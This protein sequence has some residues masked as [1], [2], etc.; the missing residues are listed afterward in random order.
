MNRPDRPCCPPDQDAVASFATGRI[1]SRGD[2][3][4]PFP[5]PEGLWGQMAEEGLFRIGMDG[6]YG[7][8]GGGY[9][10]LAATG[11]TL[12]RQGRNMGVALS[13]LYQQ[14]VARFLIQGFGSSD[15]R[16]ACLPAMAEGRLTV[17]FAVSEPG[18]GAHPKHLAATASKDGPSYL[19]NGEKAYL[20]NGPLADAFIVVAVSSEGPPRR[21]FTAFLVPRDTPG[22]TVAPPLSVP[23]LHPAPHGGIGLSDCRVP[24]AAVLGREGTAYEDMVI[25]FGDVEDALWGA[26]ALGGMEAQIDMLRE[27]PANAP[28]LTHESLG[29]L[30]VQ[31]AALG[32]ICQA[33]V[34]RL[35]M[36]ETPSTALTLAFHDLS[37]AFQ[38]RI[39]AL[40]SQIG[41]DLPPAW[42]TLLRDLTAPATIKS[43]GMKRKREKLGAAFLT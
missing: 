18:R 19:L 13:W 35:D 40:V 17:S 22:L 41:L 36:S 6:I 15:Q 29:E 42:S 11:E 3:D 33:A 37:A 9:E 12:V 26:L 34:H 23:F 24:V 5:F 8:L 31:K 16:Q 39:M 28:P 27:V 30:A 7:G 21:R 4:N 32:A 43:R 14:L 38:A 2:L 1:A 10:V 25:P 20:T